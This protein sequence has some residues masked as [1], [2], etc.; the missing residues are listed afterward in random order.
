M[1]LVQAAW[2]GAALGYSVV[3]CCVVLCYAV[4]CV[5]LCYAVYCAVL[6]YAVCASQPTML[7]TAASLVQQL[8][9]TSSS[10]AAGRGLLSC[11]MLHTGDHYS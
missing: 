11:H 2:Q 3:L 10:P 9:Q 5:L 4:C 7:T 6:C 1:H 8:G